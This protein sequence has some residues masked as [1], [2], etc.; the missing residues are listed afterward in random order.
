[1]QPHCNTSKESPDP[2]QEEKAEESEEGS[3]VSSSKVN[4]YFTHTCSERSFNILTHCVHS[5]VLTVFHEKLSFLTNQ[6]V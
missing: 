2:K 6:I 1:M 4:G 5:C 3:D